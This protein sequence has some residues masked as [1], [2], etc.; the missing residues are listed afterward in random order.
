MQSCSAKHH[1]NTAYTASLSRI[2]VVISGEAETC[3]N[4]VTKKMPADMVNDRVCRLLYWPTY[5]ARCGIQ[6]TLFASLL[7]V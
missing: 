2:T 1:V 3:K 7:S 6:P 5:Q 4:P